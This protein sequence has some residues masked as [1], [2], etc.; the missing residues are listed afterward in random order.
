MSEKPEEQRETPIQ[1][2]WYLEHILAWSRDERTP[3][4][5]RDALR[6]LCTKGKLDDTDL[7]ELTLLCKN[8]SKGD[9]LSEI[10][11]PNLQATASKINLRYISS[12]EGVN[13]LAPNQCLTFRKKGITIVYGVNGAGKSGYA[14]ILKDACRARNPKGDRLLPN[15][16][17]E[18]K[19]RPKATIGFSIKDENKEFNWKCGETRSPH[20]SAVSVFDTKTANVHVNEKNDVYYTPF[21]LRL[22]EGLADA[23]KNIQIRIQQEIDSLKD[24]TPSYLTRPKYRPHTEVGKLINGLSESTTKE[25]VYDL[26]TLGEDDR[27]RIA[28]LQVDISHPKN[29]ANMAETLA[30]SL[31]KAD[32]IFQRLEKEMSESNVAYLRE[33]YSAAEVARQAANLAASDLFSDEPLAHVGSRV[34]RTLWEAARAYSEKKAY[35]ENPFPV[36]GKGARCVLCHQK[37]DNVAIQRFIKFDSF[38]RDELKRKEDK[39]QEEYAK[40]MAS[41]QDSYI[42]VQDATELLKS[43]ETLDDQQ[44]VETTR[45]AALTLKWRLRCVL[46]NHQ[47]G[48][49]EKV[50]PQ[51]DEWPSEKIA[52]HRKVLSDRINTLRADEESDERKRLG[53]ELSELEDRNWLSTIA[54]E[55]IAD[56]E[57]RE[58]IE[59]LKKALK[60]AATNRVTT[61]SREVANE[62]VTEVLCSQFRKEVN[63]LGLTNLP[64]SIRGSASYGTFRSH[65]DLGVGGGVRN[66]DILS[67]GEHRCVAIAAFLT[68]LALSSGQSAIVFD[69][70][71]SSLDHVYRQRLAKRLAEE[72]LRRQLIVFTHDL[73]FLFLLESECADRQACVASCS[74]ACDGDGIGIVQKDPPTRAKAIEKVLE[75]MKKHLNDVQSQYRRDGSGGWDTEASGLIKQLRESWERAVEKVVEPV[76][77]RLSD[78]VN[79]KGLIKLSV[80]RE[81]DCVKMRQAY[82][83][84]SELLHSSPEGLAP[85]W[86]SPKEIRE[87]IERLEEWLAA[88][89][90]RADSV[91]KV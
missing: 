63:E 36:T 91:S 76:L 86:P 29:Q 26:A 47:A 8:S 71:V 33:L 7:T 32:E 90:R 24:K 88:I 19:C 56:I 37:L 40:A 6:R 2:A 16:Y 10:H 31:D 3:H 35:P 64:V 70:P 53:S 52:K 49:L 82:N 21:P 68:D 25:S 14:R 41:V 59:R 89:K 60:Q 45:Q 81:D 69:D 54:D 9:P 66:S 77:K 74:V 18:T 23:C 27:A 84:L 48:S 22:L 62:I 67:E 83:R 17:S 34:W 73:T 80:L 30:N 72:G 12:V 58:K 51:A 85:H 61:K 20:L 4:W 44:L 38:V 13:A 50:L 15:V 55:V 79:T 78:R 43:M 28:R 75:G 5:Q 57:R 39:A 87:E 46:R 65:V 42:S 1:E 11:M